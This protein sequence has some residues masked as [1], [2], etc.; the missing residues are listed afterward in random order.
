MTEDFVTQLRLQLREAAL[1][2]ER[3]APFAQ[4]VVRA[5][6]HLPGPAPMAAALAVALLALV[7]AL[8][9]VALRGEP[10]PSAPKVIGTYPVASGL[11]ALA[12]GFGA[13]WTADPIRGEVLRID[14]ATRRV[15]ARIPVP[16]EALVAT[17]A[18]A[19]WAVAGDLQYG[20]D[21]GPVRLL[22]I[23][24]ATNRVVARIPLRTPAGGGFG[25]LD[26]QIDR[27]VVWVVGVAVAVPVDPASNVPG[28]QVSLTGT[29]GEAARGAVI[30]GDTVSVLTVDGRLRRLDS[31][32]GGV[33]GEARLG[34]P[35]DAYL[36]GGRPGTL[37]L[38]AGN[39]IQLLEAATGRP[40]WRAALGG[41]IRYWAPGDDV[42][43]AQVSREPGPRDRLVR[44]DAGSGRPNG[45]VAL[46]EPGVTGMAAVGR[47]LWVATPGGNIVVVR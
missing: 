22:R 31:R 44:L 14:P 26:L 5:R 1:R 37:T 38:V 6:R 2:E 13:V 39:E 3:R 46:G 11:S 16:G 43:W 28:R 25:V 9:A 12:P 27:D 36:Y 32:S 34:T 35:A 30:A 24:P 7:V 10:E 47:E 20:G 29:T 4:R 18:G 40:F 17:G 42:I 21:K 23:D 19:V 33:K 45:E 8:G 15:A 41:E